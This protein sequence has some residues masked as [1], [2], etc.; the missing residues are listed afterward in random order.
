[1]NFSRR[2]KS[3]SKGSPKTKFRTSAIVT[4][5][6]IVESDKLKFEARIAKRELYGEDYIQ[7]VNS[8][9]P[10]VPLFSTMSHVQTCNNVL[11]YCKNLSDGFYVGKIG[12]SSTAL[13]GPHGIGKTTILKSYVN[14]SPLMFNNIFPIYINY[15]N[16]SGNSILQNHSLIELVIEHFQQ[17]HTQR[18]R[19]SQNDDLHFCL[20]ELLIK[21]QKRA[22]IIIDEVDKLYEVGNVKYRPKTLKT[23]GELAGIGDDGS[24]LISTLLC[25]SSS[26]LPS[27]ISASGKTEPNTVKEFPL[28]S[29]APNLNESKFRATRIY[30][31]SSTDL[32]TPRLI[33]GTNCSVSELRLVTFI[34]GSNPREIERL[35]SEI[36]VNSDRTLDKFLVEKSL[37][38]NKI[39]NT[40]IAGKLWRKLLDEMYLKNKLLLS[41]LQTNECVDFTKVEQIEWEN[42]FRPLN[43]QT[44]DKVWVDLCSE[45]QDIESSN[46]AKLHWMCWL[47]D[48]GYLLIQN[49]DHAS[50][51]E[52]YL[53]SLLA[54][55]RS[56]ISEPVWK[57]VVS[58]FNN[59]IKPVL[60][61]A[62]A[63][64][65]ILS[66]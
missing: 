5:K 25:S 52:V 22:L 38:A 64:A 62:F 53:S 57:N 1:M 47:Y 4:P 48:R 49:I 11:G 40:T 31:A 14:F 37:E 23:L 15:S 17:H 51:D 26:R 24:G 2:L 39:L 21:D 13:I 33:L 59:K 32:N 54:L 34:V 9:R 66:L 18:Y 12:S 63:Q 61:K 7:A 58:Q 42:E 60:R 19:I 10:L 36:R 3:C 56:R 44:I 6:S 8:T 50:P 46:E 27:L 41:S 35:C 16:I 65:S 28:L 55:M 45:N 20:N 43:R 30:C 29:D